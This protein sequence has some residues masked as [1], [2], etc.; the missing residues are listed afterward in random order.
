[1]I[2]KKAKEKVV[3]QVCGKITLPKEYI[4]TKNVTNRPNLI[5][6]S[7]STTLEVIVLDKVRTYLYVNS[8]LTVETRV[9]LTT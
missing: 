3:A 1:M 8:V 2:T 5:N 6:H 7:E 9:S 4:K